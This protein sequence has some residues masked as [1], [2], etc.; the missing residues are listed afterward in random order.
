[1]RRVLVAT[2][3][4]ARSQCALR[5]AGL[6]ARRLNAELTLVHV[7]DDDQPTALIDAEKREASKLLDEKISSLPE[8]RDLLCRSAIPA[9]EAFD[10]ILRMAQT[11]RADLIV[12]GRYRKELLQD[13]FIGT[14][15]ERV[16]RTGPFPVLMVKKEVDRPYAKA[17]A[18]IDASKVSAHA[19]KTALFLALLDHVPFDIVHAYRAVGKGRLLV[20]GVTQDE[21]DSYANSERQE[22]AAE[23]HALLAEHG[24]DEHGYP[25][26][27][28]EGRPFDVI[29]RVVNEV[30]PDLLVIGTHGRSGIAKLLMGSVAEEVLRSLDVDILAVPPIQ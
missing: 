30:M 20:A 13:I 6:I 28:E 23:L 10:G 7:V 16:I 9:G 18:A 24:L 22:A 15:A 11:I 19:L 17:L 21:I 14:T 25:L 8:L 1:M 4:S 26:R 2:D 29:S 5:R 3:F 12:L 27:I